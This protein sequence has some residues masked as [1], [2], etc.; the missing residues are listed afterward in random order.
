MSLYKLG[1]KNQR[2]I[3]LEQKFERKI[4]VDFLIGDSSTRTLTRKER[5]YIADYIRKL[6]IECGG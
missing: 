3:E 5:R 2:I 4:V 6:E 1:D